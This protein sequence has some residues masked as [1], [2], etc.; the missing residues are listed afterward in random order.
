VHIVPRPSLR[1]G[2]FGNSL[3]GA[4]WGSMPK[5]TLSL[6]RRGSVVV[7]VVVF[8]GLLPSRLQ[9]ERGRQGLRLGGAGVLDLAERVVHG[10]K[11][12][13]AREAVEREL[14]IVGEA[15]NRLSREDP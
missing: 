8:V 15:L 6:Q 3:T 4:S 12:L 14:E 9:A 11:E 7:C 2:C 10:G 13:A 1:L 5:G